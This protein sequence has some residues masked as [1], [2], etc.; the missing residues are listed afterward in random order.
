MSEEQQGRN[1]AKA[2]RDA[3]VQ[4][5]IWSTMPSSKEI[6]QGRFTTRLYE[7][8]DLLGASY[9]ILDVN[10][11]IQVNIR[12]TPIF[13]TLAFKVFSYT[14]AISTKTWSCVDTCHIRRKQILSPSNSPSSSQMR[15]VCLEKSCGCLSANWIQSRCCTS[16]RIFQRSS[17]QF[18][19]TGKARRR[20]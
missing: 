10:I 14:P 12:S 1:L 18:L 4:C 19:I 2:A 9:S 13:A 11:K 20:S 16:R 17:R 8:M 6:S 5:F 7:G 15:S 3:G